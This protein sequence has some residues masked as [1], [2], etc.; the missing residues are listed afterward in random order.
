MHLT[1]LR[2][3]FSSVP[4]STFA[5]REKVPL[6]GRVEKIRRGDG[7]CS[8]VPHVADRHARHGIPRRRQPSA[9][10]QQDRQLTVLLHGANIASS[11]ATDTRN[12]CVSLDTDPFPG[13]RS[14]WRVRASVSG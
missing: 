10:A 1:G 11:T 8:L 3:R 2:L 7:S 9:C 13:L 12:S 5:K 6:F 4:C 14:A